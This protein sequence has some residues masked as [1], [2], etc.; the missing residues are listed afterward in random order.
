MS[1]SGQ[2][3][4]RRREDG[5]FLRASAGREYGLLN[6]G[7]NRRLP[8]LIARGRDGRRLRRIA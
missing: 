7:R 3:G 8:R 4:G 1:R 6:D 5:N 2:D